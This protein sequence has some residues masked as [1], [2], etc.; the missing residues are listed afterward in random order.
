MI[1]RRQG[2]VDFYESCSCFHPC[3]YLRTITRVSIFNA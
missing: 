3:Y 2:I 1:F